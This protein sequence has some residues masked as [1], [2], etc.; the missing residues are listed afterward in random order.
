M[1]PHDSTPHPKARTGASDLGPD[2]N[3]G[4][5]PGPGSKPAQMQS[6]AA[7]ELG[8]IEA[9]KGQSKGEEPWTPTGER[10][11]RSLGGLGSFVGFHGEV[12][13]GGKE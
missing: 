11:G 2:P 10:F 13:E 7:T 5:G 6:R 4:R 3:A 12:V 9:W 8:R 1:S